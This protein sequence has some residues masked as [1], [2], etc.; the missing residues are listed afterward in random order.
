MKSAAEEGDDG[1]GSNDQEKKSINRQHNSGPKKRDGHGWGT[2]ETRRESLGAESKCNREPPVPFS[3]WVTSVDAGAG[4]AERERERK[5]RGG[6]EPRRTD[7]PAGRIAGLLPSSLTF[8]PLAAL[9]TLETNCKHLRLLGPYLSTY[10]HL[11]TYVAFIPCSRGCLVCVS[12]QRCIPGYVGLDGTAMAF[13][14][15][16]VH[17][18][19]IHTYSLFHPDPNGAPAKHRRW[20]NR[21][22]PRITWKSI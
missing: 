11:H 7:R 4:G 15:M 10:F 17:T 22:R 2:S 3:T 1:P 16:Y 19:Y 13:R 6:G 12:E 20:M 18:L 8:P 5:K 9:L 14:R 21:L